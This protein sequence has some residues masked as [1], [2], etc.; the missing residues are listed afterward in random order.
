MF[1]L[2]AQI[3]ENDPSKYIPNI[4]P[5]STT[6]YALGTYGNTPIG[7]FTGS[8]NISIPIYTYK[9][10]NLEVPISMFYSSN[11]IKVDE[12]SSNVGQSWNLSFGGVITRIVRDKPDEDRGNFPIPI[13]IT[14]ATG[15]YSPQALDF[16]QYIGEN[17]VDTESDIFSFN[18]GKYSGKFIFTYE[19]GILLMPA[20]ELKIEYTQNSEGIN[21]TITAPDGVKYYFDNQEIT[22]QRVLGGGHSIP[23]ITVSSWYLSRIVHPK[24]DQIQFTYDDATSTYTTSKSQTYRMLYPRIQYDAAGNLEQY[25][26]GLSPMY[27]HTMNVAGKAIKSIKSTNPFYGE[28]A[29]TYLSTSSADVTTGNNKISQ[30]TIKDKNAAEI[31]RINFT[32]T[33]TPNSRVFLDKVQFKDVN[34]NYQFEYNN[35]NSFPARLSLSQDHWGYYNG[36]NNTNIVPAVDA[37]ELQSVSYN[38]ANKDPDGNFAKI[39]LLSKIIY[40]T[41]GYTTFDYEPNDYYGQITVEPTR[42][43]QSISAVTTEETNTTSSQ[44][45]YANGARTQKV[46][47][48]AGTGFYCSDPSL[49]TGKSK[50]TISVYNT[51][52][53]RYEI[54]F[55]TDNNAEISNSFYQITPNT[56]SAAKNFYFVASANQT[57]RISISSDWFC[58]S[59]TLN[60][61]YLPGNATII[62]GNVKTGGI[63]VQRTSD[64]ASASSAP[65]IKRFLYAK[66]D[67]L[68]KSTGNKGQE[69]YYIDT[70]KVEKILESPGAGIFGVVST[71]TYL[72]LSSSSLASLFDTGSSNVFYNYVTISYGSDNFLNGGEEHEFIV[73]RDAGDGFVIGT[74]DIRSVPLSNLG[75]DN[76]LEKKVTYF[77]KDLKTV[78]QT[79]NEYEERSALRKEVISYSARK[80]YEKILS[81]P[82]NYECTQAD[83]TKRTPYWRCVANHTHQI[84]MND[85]FFGDG[86]TCIA[87]G[88]DNR[89]MYIEHPCYGLTLPKTISNLANIDNLSIV[90]YKNY[91]FW[92]YLKST[93]E[94]TYD[95]NGNNPVTATTN[96]NYRGI[97]HTLL[98]SQSS[99]NSKNE[100]LETKYFYPK[101]SEMSAKPIVNQLIAANIIGVPLDTQNYKAG[102]LLSEQLTIYDNNT[103][104]ANL[105]L[106]V[107]VYAAKFPNALPN[108]TT[109]SI[110]QLEKKITFNQYDTKGN[111]LQYTPESGIPVSIIWGYNQTQPIAKIE[112]ASYSEVLSY[113][114]NLQA[115]SD[116]GTEAEL[117]TALNVLRTALPN[118]MVTTYTY[119]PLI[120][121]STV[122]DP[123]GFITTYTYD[124]FG[125]LET[126]KDNLGNILS[127]N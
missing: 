67:D 70:Y 39:G 81:A 46:S 106:P 41:E 115:K 56:A 63:R 110:G 88:H 6:A 3:A 64:Y 117:I 22:T 36:K 80:N 31:D 76:G 107:S 18:F 116:T 44:S 126:V 105:P 121:V 78:K 101:D 123:K 97:N 119:K 92:H 45:I 77:N 12:I 108:I 59:S 58:T 124:S 10:A 13:S 2:N 23:N 72:N 98:S 85:M 93:Q 125:R 20:Q 100:L 7:L 82:V 16:Y 1:S 37:Y 27:E 57:Y 34:Q 4:I 21:F 102:T 55:R 87:P 50:A 35:R 99:N 51:T 71:A 8:Q 14:E 42:V 17:D 11:G 94:I 86:Y 89:T 33:T 38:G 91:A 47:I 83:L 113:V 122:T 43:Y 69:P 52:A 90:S 75:W 120:G 118:A 25:T 9:T 40:P 62:P 29:F 65:V 68:A 109:P 74:G 79:I 30:I 26:G 127:E 28:V 73:H 95:L 114:S 96:Y 103:T 24:G 104:T 112:N 19:G 66:K 49:D 48:I 60:Y 111:I 15:R 53:G 32:Y 54:L 84:L 5:P 61:N